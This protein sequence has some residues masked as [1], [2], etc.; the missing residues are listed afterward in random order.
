MWMLNNVMVSDG[1]VVF[2]GFVRTA[3][4]DPRMGTNISTNRTMPNGS[5]LIIS[6]TALNTDLPQP[7]HA[8]QTNMIQFLK[9]ALN[10][11]VNKQLQPTGYAGS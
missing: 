7:Y 11:R 6:N 10:M 4:T 8:F 5:F 3:H 2:Q 9:E 1:L